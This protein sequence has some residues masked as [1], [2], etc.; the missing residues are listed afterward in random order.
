MTPNSLVVR[1]EDLVQQTEDTMRAVA[2]HIGVDFADGILAPT[3]MEE[4]WGRQPRRYLL[5]HALLHLPW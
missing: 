3:V 5:N 1:Y 4:P 2:T